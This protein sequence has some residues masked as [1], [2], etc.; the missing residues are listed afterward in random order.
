MARASRFPPCALTSTTPAK[1]PRAERTSSTSTSDSTSWPMSRVPGNA[2]CSPLAPYGSAG[3][4]A[5]PSRAAESP[6]ATAAAM[7]ASV[8]RGRCGPCCSSDP[9]GTARSLRPAVASTCGQVAAPRSTQAAGR[10]APAHGHG[11]RHRR[12]VGTQPGVARDRPGTVRLRARCQ[13][14]FAV[15]VDALGVGAVERRPVKNLAAMHPPRQA[16]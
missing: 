16:S 13:G 11:N 14:G 8:S 12:T 2:A 7:R 10:N 1:E 6:T 3:A 5:M 15:A 4:T 9:N